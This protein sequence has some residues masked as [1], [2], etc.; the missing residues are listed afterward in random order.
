MSLIGRKWGGL[1]L[2]VLRNLKPCSFMVV[3]LELDENWWLGWGNE[4]EWGYSSS[5]KE[6]I[7]LLRFWF[8][9][10]YYVYCGVCCMFH[11]SRVFKFDAWIYFSLILWRHSNNKVIAGRFVE[12]LLFQIRYSYHGDF[13]TKVRLDMK[14]VGHKIRTKLIFE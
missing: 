3:I 13:F 2:F 1:C 11:V 5:L 14:A 8:N 9:P 6:Y 12:N 4:G 7:G 10:E